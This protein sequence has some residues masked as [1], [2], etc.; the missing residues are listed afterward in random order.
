MEPYPSGS[1]K[2]FWSIFA[3]TVLLACR[4]WTLVK[5]TLDQM[6]NNARLFIHTNLGSRGA[7]DQDIKHSRH[8]RKQ[9]VRKFSTFDTKS[10]G[11]DN[12]WLAKHTY[13]Q[14]MIIDD[15]GCAMPKYVNV[16]SWSSWQLWF[17]FHVISIIC[18][19]MHLCMHKIN[20][21]TCVL[22]APIAHQQH[23]NSKRTANH[24]ESS[25]LCLQRIWC[26]SR[27]W[28]VLQI[29]RTF[30]Q[31]Q[32][33]VVKLSADW[34]GSAST[35]DDPFVPICIAATTVSAT[36]SNAPTGRFRWTVTNPVWTPDEDEPDFPNFSSF[37]INLFAL[38][39]TPDVCLSHIGHLVDFRVESIMHWLQK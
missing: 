19:K 29:S 11:H 37:L 28:F 17:E 18:D 39:K 14:R 16:W 25:C 21:L 8:R 33:V 30:L 32:A 5:T 24:N 2:K 9:R 20:L 26:S 7:D 34:V 4:G 31:P 38:L 35:A 13:L 12:A 22:R 1:H 3:S 6:Q 27:A 23:G 36:T 10:M 15:L